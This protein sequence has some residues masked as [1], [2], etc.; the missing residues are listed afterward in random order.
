MIELPEVVTLTRQMQDTLAGKTIEQVELAETRPKF[1]FLTPE[2]PGL[3]KKLAGCRIAGVSSQGKWTHIRLDNDETLLIGEFGGRLH[4]HETDID[5]PTKRHL[6]FRFSDGSAMTLAIQMW[7][8]V[9]ALTQTEV[10]EHPYAGNLGPAPFGT[11]FTLERLNDTLDGYL[12]T[13]TKPI[14]AFL[15]HEANLCGIGNGYL[16]DILFRARLNPKRKVDT[17]TESDRKAHHGALRETLEEAIDLG[18]RDTERTLFGEPG[19]YVPILDRRANGKPCTVCGTPIQ[20]IQY[21][22]GSCYICPTCQI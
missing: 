10:A 3:E 7:G 6:A 4:F 8:F 22:G 17:L 21:L 18:G 1:L 2:P 14:K 9:G 15:T 12:E 11:R 16:Q 5:L 19:G 20:K 13:E